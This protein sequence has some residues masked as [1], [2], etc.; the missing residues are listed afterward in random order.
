MDVSIGER[1]E[2]LVEEAAKSGRFGSASEVVREGLRLDE[3]REATFKAL[4]ETIDASIAE[5]GSLTWEEV[6]QHLAER[7]NEWEAA[8][9]KVAQCGRC[10]LTALPSG[11]LRK[12]RSS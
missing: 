2:S 3:E 5:G 11:T 6:E 12:S 7:L 9:A 4:R 1:W 8:Q 10:A